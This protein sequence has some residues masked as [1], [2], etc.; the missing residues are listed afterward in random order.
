MSKFV[1]II[2]IGAALLIGVTALFFTIG[3]SIRIDPPELNSSQLQLKPHET[4]LAVKIS[5]P[6][7]E[8][9]AQI[10]SAVKS[11]YKGTERLNIGGNIH[12]ERVEYLVRPGDT[13]VTFG[14]QTA[15][16]EAPFS[17]RASFKAKL[18]PLGCGLGSTG[19]SETIDVRGSASV[20]INELGVNPDY[21][22]ASK[23]DLG[24]D[25]DQAEVYLFGR[26]IRVSI[27]GKLLDAFNRKK[28]SIIAAIQERLSEMDVGG[29]VQETWAETDHIIELTESP[30]TWAILVPKA[31][32][33][34][35][36]EFLD[37]KA[38]LSV[39]IVMDTQLHV[40]ERP[41]QPKTPLPPVSDI[42]ANRDFSINVPVFVDLATVASFAN[43]EYPKVVVGEG[44]SQTLTLSKFEIEEGDGRLLVSAAFQTSGLF[45]DRGR[46]YV[47]TQPILSADG[48]LL[49]FHD[50]KLTSETSSKLTENG[51][52][53]LAPFIVAKVS[54]ELKI[55]LSEH[56]DT[57]RAE[58]SNSL[59]NFP[60]KYGIKPELNLE[61][62]RLSDLQLGGGMLATIFNVDGELSID[63]LS[64]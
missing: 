60:E 30:K 38:S 14:D 45:K 48:K 52:S 29:Q 61:T 17:G 42:V 10:R 47:W 28:P 16:I 57:A 25:L 22:V 8:V 15:R 43:D 12:D 20:H 39:D 18:C 55:D 9:E 21:S 49:V 54:E 6:Q 40:G 27:R 59:S 13:S 50:V 37:G 33:I 32:G 3:K 24:L 7:S 1:K 23:V 58:I 36:L 56:Y 26:G 44:S 35:P 41:T 11:E 53:A 19:L 64:D 63:V 51:L 5:V 62:L 31:V 34:A 4:R 2:V 46:L